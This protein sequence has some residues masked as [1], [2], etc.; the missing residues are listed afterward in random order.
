LYSN[1]EKGLLQYGNDLRDYE[2]VERFATDNQVD[3]I[4]IR[5]SQ[6]EKELLPVFKRFVKIKEFSGRKR[7]AVIYRSQEFLGN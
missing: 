1:K 3:L 2:D 5:F 7:I 4:I 6:K